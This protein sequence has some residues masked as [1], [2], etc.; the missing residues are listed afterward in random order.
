MMKNEQE[1]NQKGLVEELA[2]TLAVSTLEKVER[3]WRDGDVPCMRNAEVTCRPRCNLSHR[4]D[5]F[6]D[7]TA[8]SIPVQG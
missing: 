2:P 3:V 8:F 1:Q 7:P 5:T 4:V 6:P